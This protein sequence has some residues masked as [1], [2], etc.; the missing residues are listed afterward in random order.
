MLAIPCA[1]FVLCPGCKTIDLAGFNNKDEH[2]DEL[3]NT[4][5]IKGPLERMLPWN[6]KP[7]L[8]ELRRNPD[9]YEQGQ[10]EFKQA[11]QLYEQKKWKEAEKRLKSISTQYD[12]Y[13]VKE[14]ALYLLGEIYFQTKRYAKAV[15]TFDTLVDKFPATRYQRQISS[16]LF[17]IAGVWLDFP[18]VVKP[19][20][21]QLTSNLENATNEIKVPE[22]KRNS[23]DPTLTIPILP[24]LHNRVRPL[25]DTEGRAL[26]ALKSIW[27][28]DP[29]SELADDALMMTASHYLRKGDSLQAD[30]YFAELRQNYPDSP[31][32]KNS[33]ILGSHV[34]L[35]SYEGSDYDGTRLEEA[36]QL[37]DS[38][39]RM[40]PDDELKGRLEQEQKTIKEAEALRE[41]QR[42][43]FYRKKGRLDSAAIY[44]R[45]L[46][47][48]YP[49]S[50]VAKQAEQFLAENP[51][52]R[53][54]EETVPKAKREPAG[55]NWRLFP[56][57]EKVPEQDDPEQKTESEEEPD[58]R[59]FPSK[60]ENKPYDDSGRAKL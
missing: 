53:L 54:T 43:Q 25:F 32:F 45:E 52:P 12:D 34:K 33:F 58:R 9:Y 46:I 18:D 16:H 20:D 27:L 22:R 28:N 21:V 13:A 48:L 56:R 11:S 51:V 42:V 7:D 31:H 49:D 38:A 24:N 35:M 60:D 59:Y 36:K 30:E 5:K 40:W 29:T 15:D 57:L 14:D 44:C 47:H 19:S 4:S 41:W 3:A 10:N 1:V 26:E 2:L 23:W 39:M 50:Q 55:W 8:E 17:T 37:N 6:E